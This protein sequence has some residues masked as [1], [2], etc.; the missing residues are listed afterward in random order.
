VRATWIAISVFTEARANQHTLICQTLFDFQSVGKLRVPGE[1]GCLE[2][3]STS[4]DYIMG[5]CPIFSRGGFTFVWPRH[6]ALNAL[7]SLCSDSLLLDL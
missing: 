6:A 5:L 3:V 2:S 1:D 4:H 7:A